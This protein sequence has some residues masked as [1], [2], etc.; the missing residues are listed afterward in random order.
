[1]LFLT[2]QF[3]SVRSL[4]RVR[5]FVTPGTAARQAS[6]SITNSQSL[7]KL[8]SIESV[9]PSSHLTL[10]CPLLLPPSIFPSNR[11]FSS[12]SAL[13]IGVLEFQ[14]QHQAFQWTFRTDFL[15][16]WLVGSPCGLTFR[17]FC[18]ASC[19]SAVSGLFL[20][21]RVCQSHFSLVTFPGF[22]N[23]YLISLSREEELVVRNCKLLGQLLPLKH[24]CFFHVL[25]CRLMSNIFL[26]G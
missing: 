10:C 21:L 7:L 24:W 26:K 3:S 4:S 22:W 2:F 18:C 23:I 11:V 13:R 19:F 1:M 6:L 8:T 25:L 15:Y 17:R 12:E 5:L 20:L 9:M 14:R 16:D